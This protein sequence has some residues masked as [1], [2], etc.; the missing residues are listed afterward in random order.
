MQPTPPGWYHAEGDPEG[1]IRYW[2]GQQW[3]G[4]PVTAPPVAA[5]AP[6]KFG[7]APAYASN[8]PAGPPQP[9]RSDAF[10]ARLFSAQGRVNRQTYAIVSIGGYFASIVVAIVVY[11]LAAVAG[12]PELGILF[13]YAVILG[14]I[15]PHIATAVKRLHDQNHSG[16]FVLLALVPFASLVLGVMC[17]FVAGRDYGNAYGEPPDPGFAL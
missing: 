1:T 12:L 8:A 10:L 5:A 4:G 6:P 13:L 2:D 14:W 17:L 3:V 9:P 11:G 15:W 7:E 16:W